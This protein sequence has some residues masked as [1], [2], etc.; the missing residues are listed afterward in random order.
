MIET[1]FH[2]ATNTFHIKI[3]GS[4]TAED[5]AEMFPLL[6]QIE[7]LPDVLN[8]LFDARFGTLLLSTNEI[9]IMINEKRE[10]LARFKMVKEAIVV[11]VALQTA[12]ALFYQNIA[13]SRN[14]NLKVFSELEAAQKWLNLNKITK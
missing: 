5:L 13:H 9:K 10:R 1:I 11:N 14:Y 6:F 7:D 4:A 3:T 12:L 2:R 8:V